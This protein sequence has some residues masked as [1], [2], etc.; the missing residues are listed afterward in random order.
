[1]LTYYTAWLKTYYPLEF[2]FSVL[3]NEND[4]DAKTGYLIEAKRLNLKILLPDIN[5]SNVY[6]S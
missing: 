4:K 2:M 6:F 3:K 5:N 1:M